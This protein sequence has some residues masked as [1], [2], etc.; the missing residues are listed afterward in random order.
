MGPFAARP[1][2]VRLPRIVKK[3]SPAEK[4]S[5]GRKS[6]PFE[7]QR[8]LLHLLIKKI[9]Y[10][11]KPNKIRVTFWDIPD[12]KKPPK[13]PKKGNSGG[14]ASSNFDMRMK[15]LPRSPKNPNFSITIYAGM[16]YKKNG[17]RWNIIL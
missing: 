9:V 5:S 7:K 2:P 15:W 12:I 16:N 6:L 10:L 3:R 17:E 11:E 1:S 13:R 4:I 8:D 14:L